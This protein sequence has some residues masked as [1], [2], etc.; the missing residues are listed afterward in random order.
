MSAVAM[1]PMFARSGVGAGVGLGEGGATGAW[2]AVGDAVAAAVVGSGDGDGDA[3]G[4]AVG[5]GLGD[6]GATVPPAVGGG[7]VGGAVTAGVPL[8]GVGVVAGA[9][10]VGVEAARGTAATGTVVGVIGVA[11]TVG[12]GLSRAGGGRVGTVTLG[13]SATAPLHA[14][15]EVSISPRHRQRINALA[16]DLA[17]VVQRRT[18]ALN[19]RRSLYRASGSESTRQ[20][21]HS[22]SVR[23]V[24]QRQSF[25]P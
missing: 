21:R 5:D 3:S 14:A 8:G 18:V 23:Q 6:G 13:V 10:G 17:R 19:S 25:C 2:V 16:R 20:P 11:A 7:W 15:R 9:V 1:R 22:S 24:Y 12:A 4:G